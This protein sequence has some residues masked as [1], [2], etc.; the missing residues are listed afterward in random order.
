MGA[1]FQ[2]NKEK[3]VKILSEE[4]AY[5]GFF[6][7]KK[8]KLKHR[9]FANDWSNELSRELFIRPPVAA[10]LPYDPNQDKVVLIQQFRLGA[11]ADPCPWLI[12][13]VAGVNDHEE[14]DP[15]KLIH[16]ELAEESQLEAHYLHKIYEYWT[17]P[18][19]SNEYLT[20][21]CAKVTAPNES[22]I[23]GLEA[24]DEDILVRSFDTKEAFAMLAKGVFRNA[25]TI[26]ALQW[27]QLHKSTLDRQW[28]D[29]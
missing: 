5:E 28:K 17:S 14:N 12:E 23:C 4:S 21:Y 19:G 26:I 3:D 29:S 18:G 27:L 25:I 2:L 9:K 8:Y 13:I 7:I 11:L 22:K 10:A 15:E 6:K 16:R 24:E 20:L 1:D